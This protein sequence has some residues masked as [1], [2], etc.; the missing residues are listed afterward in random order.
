MGKHDDAEEAAKALATM[1]YERGSFDNISCIVCVFNF[2]EGEDE[3]SAAP[4][5]AA[6]GEIME[7][8]AVAAFDTAHPV[9]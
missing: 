2:P 5:K 7:K 4:K 3:A 1:A 6:G 8:V 9:R